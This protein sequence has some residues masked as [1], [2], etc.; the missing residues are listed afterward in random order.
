MKNRGVPNN[1]DCLCSV[2]YDGESKR[3]LPAEVLQVS[4]TGTGRDLVVPKDGK[5]YQVMSYIELSVPG[6]FAVA[7]GGLI[8]G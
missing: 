7:L 4:K 8:K 2:R 5:Q 6:T 3:S 1:T